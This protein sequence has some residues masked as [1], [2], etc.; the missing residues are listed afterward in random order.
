[1]IRIPDPK[2][3]PDHLFAYTG[4]E[5]DSEVG[6]QANQLRRFDPTVG[7]WLNDEPVGYQGD[8]ALHRY[9]GNR[10]Q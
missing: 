3:A 10:P 4:R 8:A 1:M 5:S 6:L 2:P 9:V 7:R